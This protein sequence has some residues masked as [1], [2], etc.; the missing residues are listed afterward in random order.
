M[1]TIARVVVNAYRQWL[2]ELGLTFGTAWI[3]CQVLQTPQGASWNTSVRM[4]TASPHSSIEV[5]WGSVLVV[6]ALH[7]SSQGPCDWQLSV[8]SYLIMTSSTFLIST[9]SRGP[10]ASMRYTFFDSDFFVGTSN[11][12]ILNR[13]SMAKIPTTTIGELLS[14]G[15]RL[16]S[17]WDWLNALLN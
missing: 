15:L 13:I 6:H 1:I 11:I 3:L 7:S 9:V 5:R 10:C 14:G 4:Y 12:P 8:F 2:R 16:T 17:Q